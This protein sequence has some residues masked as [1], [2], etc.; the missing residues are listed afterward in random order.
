MGNLFP[1]PGTQDKVPA[2]EFHWYTG[3]Y[4]PTTDFDSSR[5]G[6]LL[7][8]NYNVSFNDVCWGCH[9]NNG[10]IKYYRGPCGPKKVTVHSVWTTDTDPGNTPKT[11][12]YPGDHI[13]YHVSFTIGGRDLTY[14]VQD[15]GVAQKAD[16]TGPQFKFGHY[17][18][19]VPCKTYEWT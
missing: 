3:N 7:C 4:V 19:L 10:E 9:L 17:E 11:I 12:F 14:F 13:R 8:D 18:T 2:L 5:W 16:G 1:T 15:Q 6:G